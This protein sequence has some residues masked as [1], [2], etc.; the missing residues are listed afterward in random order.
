MHL[1]ASPAVVPGEIIDESPA[2]VLGEVAAVG[3]AS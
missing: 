1:E 3:A 2:V